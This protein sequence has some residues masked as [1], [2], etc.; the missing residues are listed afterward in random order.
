MNILKTYLESHIKMLESVI[1]L[2]ETAASHHEKGTPE[3]E[4]YLG[5]LEAFRFLLKS[6]QDYLKTLEDA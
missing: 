3:N 2:N 4:F 6:T 5:K 1:A